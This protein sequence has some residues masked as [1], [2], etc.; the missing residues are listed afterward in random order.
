MGN[1]MSFI[2]GLQTLADF[3]DDVELMLHVLDGACIR[4]LVDYVSNLLFDGHNPP[5]VRTKPEHYSES[6]II[7]KHGAAPVVHFPAVMCWSWA[8]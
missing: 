6:G 4:K 2:N 7:G 8:R 3:F 1:S 5:L